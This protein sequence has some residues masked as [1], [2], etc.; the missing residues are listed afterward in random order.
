MATDLRRILYDDQFLAALENLSFNSRRKF[1]GATK[2]DFLGKRTGASLEFADHRTYNP[3]DDIRSVD[4]NLLARM[5]KIFVKLFKEEINL[6][7]YI[8]VDCSRSMVYGE[9]AKLLYAVKV[10]AALSYI[11]VANRERVG[12]ATFSDKIINFA[13]P[14]KGKK[15]IYYLFDFLGDIVPNRKTDINNSLK[16]FINQK[17]YSGI[18]VVISDFLDPAGYEEGFKYLLHKRFDVNVVQVLAP[19]DLKPDLY[20]PMIMNDL[21]G[22][23]N[24]TLNVN[25]H[26]LQQFRQ[27]VKEENQKLALFCRDNRIQY[28]QA[29]TDVPFEKM[30]MD[31]FRGYTSG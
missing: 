5:D 26:I 24:L 7:I 1:I 19:E 13:H 15:Q 25:E 27:V 6:F 3:G 28:F 14:L 2:G 10:A 11:G 23:G 31:Y 30:V 21:E 20:G 16:E 4:W 29:M 22:G 9:S 12:I 17:V 18:V 8:L